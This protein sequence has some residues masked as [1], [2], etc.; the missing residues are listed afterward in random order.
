[1]P[2]E[3]DTLKITKTSRWRGALVAT[4]AL[5]SWAWAAPWGSAPLTAAAQAPAGGR[6][7]DSPSQKAGAGR[8]AELFKTTCKVCHGEAG[9]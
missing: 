8:G 1:M 9:M 3:H 2:S 4:I 6:G 5:T 7:G